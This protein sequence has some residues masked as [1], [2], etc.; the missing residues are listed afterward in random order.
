M[1]L[2]LPVREC[3]LYPDGSVVVGVSRLVWIL[4]VVELVQK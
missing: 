2:K 4:Y 3:I 1:F